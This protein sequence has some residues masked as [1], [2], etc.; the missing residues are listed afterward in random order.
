MMKTLL[1]VL[2]L[3]LALGVTAQFDPPS[4]L[5]APPPPSFSFSPN[6][7]TPESPLSPISTSPSSPISPVSYSPVEISVVTIPSAFSYGTGPFSP[8]TKIPSHLLG[9]QKISP[10]PSISPFSIP[11]LA[12]FA[13]LF[14]SHSSDASM[15]QTSAGVAVACLAVV[16]AF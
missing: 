16:L 11:P 10:L 3:G 4:A 14:G 8:F 5:E 12:P 7:F 9:S 2:V 13:P 1:A 6:Y 15:L